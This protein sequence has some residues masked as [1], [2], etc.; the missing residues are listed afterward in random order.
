V[1]V[2]AATVL[3]WSICPPTVLYWPLKPTP[4]VLWIVMVTERAVRS[5][6]LSS[7][8][9]CSLNQGLLVVTAGVTVTPPVPVLPFT[10]RLKAPLRVNPPPVP[11]TVTFTVPVVAAL[12]AARVSVLLAPVVDGG[13]KVAVTPLG[14]PVALKATLLANPPT[15]L[16]LMVVAALAPRFTVRVEGLAASVKFCALAIER[17]NVVERVRPPP[18]PLIATLK[19]P[20][21]AALDAARVSMLFPP[22]VE[23]GLNVAVTPLGNP[24]ALKATLP[25]NP[26]VRVMVI[27]LTPLAPGLTVRLDGFADKVKSCALTVRVNVVVRVNPPPPPVIVTFVVPVA[28]V[29]DTAINI[30]MTETGPGGDSNEA[31]TPLG[32][33][34]AFK[35]TTLSNPPMR[36]IVTVAPLLAPRLMVKLDGFTDSVKSGGG[37]SLTV[38]LKVVD[39]LRPPPEPLIVTLNVPVA[40]V[41]EAASVSVLLPPVVEAG[42]NVA[43]TPLGNPLAL[44]ATLPVN[45]PL[46]VMVIVL[47]LLA[48][49]LMVRLGRLAES[50]KF[51]LPPG[52]CHVRKT[53]SA[54]LDR[55]L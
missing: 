32:N 19:V 25:V 34:L 17:A 36:V 9:T 40:A 18:E 55:G 50:V 21:A 33:P 35:A 31:V 43:A 10:V 12:E 16:M 37:G 13:L 42:L 53:V 23:G 4:V 28:A 3:L 41:L 8:I 46:R 24:L 54:G 1:I 51:G 39:R 38:R 5:A 20:N 14:N 48:P 15:R 22:V 27:V 2:V 7:R 52:P 29:L 30:E 11:L 49:R 44:K 6:V 47:T 26:P 45:P